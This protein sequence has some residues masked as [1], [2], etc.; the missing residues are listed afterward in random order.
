MKS[1]RLTFALFLS[2]FAFQV[3]VN[4]QTQTVRGRIID[5]QSEAPLIG[6]TV[7]L[8]ESDPMLG[9][10]TDVDG[11]FTLPNVPVGRQAFRVSYLGYNTI[12]VPNILVTSGKEVQLSLGLEE[13]ITE[14]SEVVVKADV[15]KDRPINEMATISARQFNV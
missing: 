11:N 1:I 7:E 5:Q 10:V 14:L 3:F 12:T 15:N 9:T 2:L 6:A 4:A 13:S 8:L